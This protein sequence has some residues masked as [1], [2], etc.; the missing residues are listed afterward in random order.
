MI[1][2]LFRAVSP[3]A[4]KRNR[5][6]AEQVGGVGGKRGES[7]G[8]ENDADKV[9]HIGAVDDFVDGACAD[10]E[11]RRSEDIGLTFSAV[12]YKVAGEI[13]DDLH[14]ASGKNALA[15]MGSG[16]DLRVPQ[17]SDKRRER[18]G[19]DAL[20]V[21]QGDL[22]GGYSTTRGRSGIGDAGP[23]GQNRVRVG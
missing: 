9:G 3:D 13:K 18:G 4:V 6:V 16:V 23:V 20:E 7:A 5:L 14:A 15:F 12:E 17:H 21:D 10:Y 19:G 2:E 22:E 8:G 1:A 11:C